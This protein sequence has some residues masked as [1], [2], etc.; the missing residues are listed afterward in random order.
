[1]AGQKEYEVELQFSSQT[2]KLLNK[3]IDIPDKPLY[4]YEK[5]KAPPPSILSS[6]LSLDSSRPPPYD[7]IGDNMSD[8]QPGPSQYS[9]VNLT[10]DVPAV[11]QRDVS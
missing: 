10:I 9:G 7:E 1:M 11:P 8:P 4:A 3:E 2:S 6:N 5:E